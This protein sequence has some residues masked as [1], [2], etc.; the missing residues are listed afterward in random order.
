MRL[1]R[2][3][4]VGFEAALVEEPGDGGDAGTGEKVGGTR[5]IAVGRKGRKTPDG[6]GRHRRENLRRGY[7][8]CRLT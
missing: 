4:P 7:A 6:S 1:G 2:L 8:G 3:D 5:E